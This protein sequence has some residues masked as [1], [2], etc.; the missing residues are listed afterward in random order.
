[1]LYQ[2]VFLSISYLISYSNQATPYLLLADVAF[3]CSLWLLAFIAFP[4]RKILGSFPDEWDHFENRLFRYRVKLDIR[5][6]IRNRAYLTK[7]TPDKEN[8]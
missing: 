8:A 2:A 4:V 1:L 6:E 5:D 7:W 3:G